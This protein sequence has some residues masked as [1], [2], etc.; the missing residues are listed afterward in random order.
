M[1]KEDVGVCGVTFLEESGGEVGRT[2]VSDLYVDTGDFSELVHE[3]LNQ[4][5]A[6]PRVDDERSLG[7]TRPTRGDD[8]SGG[9]CGNCETFQD[10]SLKIVR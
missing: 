4:F 8:K 10:D 1:C 5:L 9:R 6:S 3:R 2:C 7:P